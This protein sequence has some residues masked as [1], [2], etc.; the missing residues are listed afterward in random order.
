[1]QLGAQTKNFPFVVNTRVELKKSELHSMSE[2]NGMG[3]ACNTYWGE[4]K[5]MF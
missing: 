4:Q 2:I 1:M 3:W 5:F